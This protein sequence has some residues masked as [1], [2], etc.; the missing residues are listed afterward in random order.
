[1]AEVWTPTD[2]REATL[3]FELEILRKIEDGKMVLADGVYCYDSEEGNDFDG[4]NCNEDLTVL[5]HDDD[6]VDID[7][8]GAL[9]LTGEGRA[10]LLH[11]TATGA[12]PVPT[13]SDP[14]EWQSRIGDDPM[15]IVELVFARQV[16]T[17]R[18]LLAQETTY[19]RAFS[20][21]SE[22]VRTLAEAQE[23]IKERS[24]FWQGEID[25]HPEFVLPGACPHPFA[26]GFGNCE[27]CGQFV[28]D[29]ED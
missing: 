25:D 17:L 16:D 11:M 7:D 3:R 10:Y 13:H 8:Y 23:I 22:M 28:D 21:H 26:D 2:Q 4:E 18:D 5:A 14:G 24:R 12:D 15:L 27:G 19:Y 29:G 9:S 20:S 1:M 6:F